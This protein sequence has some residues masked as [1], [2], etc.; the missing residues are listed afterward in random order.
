MDC[1]D[2]SESSFCLSLCWLE[3]TMT[4]LAAHQERSPPNRLSEP[5]LP[6]GLL[7]R[8]TIHHSQDRPTH[9]LQLRDLPDHLPTRRSPLLSPPSTRARHRDRAVHLDAQ[10]P[11]KGPRQAGRDR[12][13]RQ[14]RNGLST[15]TRRHW[16]HR[17]GTYGA[18]GRLDGSTGQEV[19]LDHRLLPTPPTRT[20]K[21]SLA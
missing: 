13:D 7:H 2:D 17:A 10:P 11:G 5:S 12:G 4:S 8:Q 21:L 18:R 14:A 16:P 1:E 20:S 19:F 15:R 6:K 9:L 3:L